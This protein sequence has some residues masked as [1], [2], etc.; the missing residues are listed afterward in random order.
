VGKARLDLMEA[1]RQLG[2]AVKF[3]SEKARDGTRSNDLADYT[4]P[5]IAC[6]PTHT[7]EWAKARSRIRQTRDIRPPRVGFTSAL[8]YAM[9]ATSD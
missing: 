1:V 3:G 6:V 9:K 2:G 8:N 4:A 7:P 5:D